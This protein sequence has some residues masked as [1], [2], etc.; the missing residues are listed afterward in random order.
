MVMLLSEIK[1]SLIFCSLSLG[2]R[3]CQIMLL[4]SNGSLVRRPSALMYSA[5]HFLTENELLNTSAVH[6]LTEKKPSV[7]RR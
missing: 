1:I 4:C 6:F 5:V 2:C 3:V 7:P